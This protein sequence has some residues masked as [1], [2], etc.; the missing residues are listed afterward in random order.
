MLKIHNWDD[1]QSYRKDRGQP[2]WIKIHRNIMRNVKWVGLSDKER[3]QLVSLWLLA[4]DKNGEIPADPDLLMKLCF[5]S[6]KPNLNKFIDIG[7]LDANMT[8]PR[9]HHDPPEAKAK[10]ETKAEKDTYGEFQNVFL[11]LEEYEK[12]KQQ[13]NST[14]DDKIHALSLYIASNGKKYKSHYAT[15]LSWE[16]KNGGEQTKQEEPDAFQVEYERLQREGKI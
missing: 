11:S 3:G 10:A 2:P 9:R 14:L 13:F 16:R 1:W 8:S 6:T 5:M 7:F 12:L 4:A 15:I